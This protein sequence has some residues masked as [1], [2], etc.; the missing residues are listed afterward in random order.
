MKSI[1]CWCKNGF[2]H[3]IRKIFFFLAS[4]PRS[5]TIVI[6]EKKNKMIGLCAQSRMGKDTIAD[7]I[8]SKQKKYVKYSFAYELKKLISEYFQITMEEIEDYKANDNIHPNVSLKMRNIL[9]LIGETFRSVSNDVWI[10]I[11]MKKAQSSNV[12]FT[13]VRHDNEMNAI[14]N[15]EGILILLGRSLYV[16]EDTHPSEICLKNAILWFLENTSKD[17]INVSDLDNVPTDF[18]K[19]KYFIRNDKSIKEL[20]TSIDSLLSCITHYCE[21]ADN[22]GDGEIN[23]LSSNIT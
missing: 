14:T 1:Y 15:K 5:L 2:L 17:F 22:G 16:N 9:Q 7:Y 20:Y 23:K 10:N 21:G 18:K 4:S 13:D 11:A 19:F 12:I 3:F 6:L 8:I